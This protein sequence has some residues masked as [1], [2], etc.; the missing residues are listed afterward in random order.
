MPKKH[1]PINDCW[2][3]KLNALDTRTTREDQ[4]V[5]IGGHHKALDLEEAFTLAA[6]INLNLIQ[7][8]RYSSHPLTH[9]WIVL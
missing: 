4:F 9:R 3:L 5:R 7:D 6:W 8:G 2:A 1:E